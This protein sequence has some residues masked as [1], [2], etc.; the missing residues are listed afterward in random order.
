[1]AIMSM[2]HLIRIRYERFFLS[3]NHDRMT[4]SFRK[5]NNNKNVKATN[6]MAHTSFNTLDFFFD[7]QNMYNSNE[8]HILGSS[9]GSKSTIL[10]Q[11]SWYSGNFTYLWIAHFDQVSWLLGKN[12]G[13]FING[14]FL[15]KCHFLLLSLYETLK[16]KHF[17]VYS[18]SL[19]WFLLITEGA[20]SRQ[21]N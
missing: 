14:L 21:I 8:I 10:I 5:P 1:M 17:C 13:F 4:D 2:Q 6:L 12:H 16:D 9:T 11:T 3:K 20:P 15:G 19:F 7:V 18:W